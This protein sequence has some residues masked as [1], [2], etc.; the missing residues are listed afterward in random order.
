M[1]AEHPVCPEYESLQEKQLQWAPS[2]R[3]HF[4][5]PGCVLR[6]LGAAF[7]WVCAHAQLAPNSLS[8]A[9]ESP[10]FCKPLPKRR[11]RPHT[12]SR[13]SSL[14]WSRLPRRVYRGPMCS[15]RSCQRVN[16]SPVSLRRLRDRTI[17]SNGETN[18]PL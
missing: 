14:V 9:L 6:T 18:V 7:V 5:L 2:N 1:G 15:D 10:T 4:G 12:A 13:P 3:M 8:Q 16:E 11:R 17:F